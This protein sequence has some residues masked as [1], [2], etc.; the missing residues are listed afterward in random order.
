MNR[1]ANLT[2]LAE[3]NR[4]MNAKVFEA[5]GRLDAAAL[6]ADRGAYFSSILGTLNHLVVADLIWLR[7]FDRHVARPAVLGAL[8]AWPVPAALDQLMYTDFGELRERRRR[9]DALIQDWA[10]ALTETDLDLPLE[11][12]T[13]KGEPAQRELGSLAVHFFNHQT[14]HRGQ[15]TTLLT[16][17]GQEVGV[18]DLLMLIPNLAEVRRG[19]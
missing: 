1:C 4:W 6:A 19:P 10:G 14:H 11:Y 7:R 2:L 8:A 3:Y 12:R 9:L 13:A 15:A 18:T 17:A 16:Q 5:A